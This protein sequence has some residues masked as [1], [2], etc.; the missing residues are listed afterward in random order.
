MANIVDMA[1]LKN[2]GVNKTLHLKAGPLQL[3][4]KQIVYI[5]RSNIPNMYMIAEQIRS[6]PGPAL[7]DTSGP[8]AAEV[9]L[10]RAGAGGGGSVQ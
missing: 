9:S 3:E 1:I 4:Q 7:R 8:G 10:L 5:V 6:L 2:H